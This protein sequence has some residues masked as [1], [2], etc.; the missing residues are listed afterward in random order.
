[1]KISKHPHDPPTYT[2]YPYENTKIPPK[3]KLFLSFLRLKA[4]FYCT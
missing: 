4:L 1:M 3:A 2:K